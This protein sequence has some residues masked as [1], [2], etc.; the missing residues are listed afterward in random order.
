MEFGSARV[1]VLFFVIFIGIPADVFFHGPLTI[2]MVFMALK[3]V[4]DINAELP[5]SQTGEAP[6]WQLAIAAL[7]GSEKKAKFAE[8][9]REAN[10]EYGSYQPEDEEVQTA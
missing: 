2:M 8:F 5:E 9:A 4:A 6:Q 1:F 7:F 10:R 3:T